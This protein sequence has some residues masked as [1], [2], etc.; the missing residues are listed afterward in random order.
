MGRRL[1]LLIQ[2][3]AIV[4]L[5]VSVAALGVEIFANDL[6]NVRSMQIW[7]AAA[8]SCLNINAFAAIW[9]LWSTGKRR[10]KRI[11][12]ALTVIIIVF[13]ITKFI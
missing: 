1:I 2:V 13:W 3:T 9:K 5:F 6:E 4:L 7:A 11:A 10:E 12:I 8:I